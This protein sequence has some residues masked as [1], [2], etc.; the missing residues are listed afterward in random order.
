M[1]F[2][3]FPWVCGCSACAFFCASPHRGELAANTCKVLSFLLI[4]VCILTEQL[5]LS[6][7]HSR[8]EWIFMVFFN[9]GM[10]YFLSHWALLCDCR[11]TAFIHSRKTHT[12][13]AGCAHE[14]EKQVCDARWLNQ[15]KKHWQGCC[16]GLS[17]SYWST[18]WLPLKFLPVL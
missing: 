5:V 6:C 11:K 16:S 9:L 10:F 18:I 17:C 7:F 14:K 4:P 15:Y 3:K 2:W 1:W 13:V 12:K 8:T